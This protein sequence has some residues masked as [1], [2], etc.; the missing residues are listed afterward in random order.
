M[1]H[2]QSFKTLKRKLRGHQISQEEID[3]APYEKIDNIFNSDQ[4]ARWTSIA[5]NNKR[6]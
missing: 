3:R 1:S 6:I 2:K 5:V 4:E